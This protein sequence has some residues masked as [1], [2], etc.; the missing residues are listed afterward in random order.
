MKFNVRIIEVLKYSRRGAKGKRRL[1][2]N[3]M[4]NTAKKKWIDDR[5][6]ERSS[7]ADCTLSRRSCLVAIDRR[8][9]RRHASRTR[10]MKNGNATI[11]LRSFSASR[12][13]T[14][15]DIAPSSAPILLNRRNLEFA[16]YGLSDRKK[17]KNRGGGRRKRTGRRR[18]AARV[19][20]RNRERVNTRARH[21]EGT[22]GRGGCGDT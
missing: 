10:T 8:V 20:E 21:D 11:Q 6:N 13:D 9:Q 7:C 3:R 17:K 16:A 14:D 22:A 1:R 4:G 12:R 15:S 18:K 2:K 5:R 19:R